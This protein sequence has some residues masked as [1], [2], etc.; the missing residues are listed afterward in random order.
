MAKD[1]MPYKKITFH[2]NLNG[3]V[4]NS[5]DFF[6]DSDAIQFSA[7]GNV[8]FI[9]KK[10]DL[11]VGA[12]PLQTLDLIAAKIPIAGWIVTDERGKLITVNFKIGGTWDNPDV[13]TITA[14]SIGK[15]T[16]DIFRRIFLLPEKLI[17]DTGEVILGR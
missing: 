1:G 3:G 15:G 12:H 9:K 2:T 17:T 5:K 13:T 14:Q 16:V 6:I 8:D 4:L 11:I 7:T 10:L